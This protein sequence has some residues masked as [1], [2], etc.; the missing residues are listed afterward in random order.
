MDACADASCVCMCVCV[1]FVCQVIAYNKIDL[2]DSGDYWEFVKEYLRVSYAW[3]GGGAS[4]RV[5]GTMW[6]AQHVN[7]GNDKPALCTGCQASKPLASTCP[8]AHVSGLVFLVPAPPNAC[9]LLMIML[10]TT[11]PCTALPFTRPP[12]P[13]TT[14]LPQDEEGVPEDRLFPISAVTG[15]GVREAVS[16]VRGVLDE[17]GPAEV[18]PETDALNIT[19]VPRRFA[20]EV[21]FTARHSMRIVQHS[22]GPA[23]RSFCRGPSLFPANT[24]GQPGP[25]R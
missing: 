4:S 25:D 2:P 9:P 12:H 18:A 13:P 22:A 17:L 15:R 20:P 7:A 16:A 6:H 10:H 8:R 11:P 21:R 24:P 14:L 23:H 1:C 19:E 3:R 5:G